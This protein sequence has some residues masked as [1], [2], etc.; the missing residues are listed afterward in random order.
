MDDEHPFAGETALVTGAS[1]GIGR[2]TARA[3]ARDGAAV[4]LTARREDRLEALAEELRTRYDAEALVAPTDVT[5][6][7]EVEDAVARTVDRF[8]RLDVVVANAGVFRSGDPEATPLEVHRSMLDVNVNGTLHTA[9]ASLPAL[10]DTGGVLVVTGSVAGRFP[11]PANPLYAASKWW[12]RGFALSLAGAVGDDDVAVSLVNPSE[13][14]TEAG[15]QDREPNK[16]RHEPGTVTEPEDVAEAIVFAATQES[17]NAVVELDL[18]RRDK[19][20]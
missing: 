8:G 7:A 17:P 20:Q 12:T 10:R 18:F 6:Y 13:V 11:L 1:S 19:L 5:A 3:L 14:R 9:R 2:A 16:E 4:T 15:A